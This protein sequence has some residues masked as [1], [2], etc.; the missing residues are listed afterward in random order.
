MILRRIFK[1]FA[2]I[3]LTLILLFSCFISYLFIS[4]SAHIDSKKLTTNSPTI[5]F[6]TASGK[7]IATPLSL[8]EKV[9]VDKLPSFVIDAFW[10]YTLIGIG[11]TRKIRAKL[12][13][14]IKRQL[15]HS[16]NVFLLSLFSFE[17]LAKS[18]HDYTNRHYF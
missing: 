15:K 9:D 13:I 1:G 2:F 16:K 11:R 6:L 17:I 12:K 5:I 8:N 18:T 14:S 3:F 7:Q 10:R 4:P